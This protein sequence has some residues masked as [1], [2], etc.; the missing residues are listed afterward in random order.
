MNDQ[1][2]KTGFTLIEIIIVIV[3]IGLLSSAALPKYFMTVETMRA[4]KAKEILLDI[5]AAQKR[6]FIDNDDGT[7]TADLN[8]LDITI[9]ILK[10]FDAPIALNGLN[11]GDVIASITRDGSPGDY[12]LTIDNQSNF[13]CTPNTTIP[14]SIC[15]QLRL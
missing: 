8:E 14:A 4:S 15:T 1:Y 3:I 6:L 7:Y 12:T 2:Q 9:P 5:Y 13:A 11:P 10:Y